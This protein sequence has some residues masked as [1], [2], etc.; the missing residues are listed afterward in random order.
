[1]EQMK[2]ETRGGKRPGAGRKPGRVPVRSIKL[3]DADW[4][5]LRVIGD[6]DRTAAVRKMIAANL[7]SKTG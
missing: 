7:A 6:G 1:M 3:S 2:K 4:D 5:A